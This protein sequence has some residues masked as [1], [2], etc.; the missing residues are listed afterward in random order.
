MMQK[1]SCLRRNDALLMKLIELVNDTGAIIE[2]EWFKR[3]EGVHRQLRPALPDDYAAKMSRVY[4]NGAR[5]VICSQG[6][7][8]LG[9]AQYRIYENTFDGRKLY[10]DDLVTDNAHRSQGVGKALLDYLE[11]K[12]RAQNCESVCLDSGVQRDQAHKFYF[13][14]GFIVTSFSFKKKVK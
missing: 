1:D 6:D 13:R 2:P 7:T 5:T 14:E 9:I 8:V 10:V 11:Q 4:A 12:A 3:A